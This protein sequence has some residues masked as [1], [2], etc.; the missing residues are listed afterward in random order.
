M[1]SFLNNLDFQINIKLKGILS[2]LVALISNT[3]QY[4]LQMSIDL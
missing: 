1:W 4:N 2:L 3:L